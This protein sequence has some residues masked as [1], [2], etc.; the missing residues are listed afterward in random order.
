MFLLL[1][2][3]VLSSSFRDVHAGI[4]EQNPHCR[5]YLAESTIPNAGL[6]I[7]TGI[8]LPANVS[9]A[10]PDIIV[11]LHDLEFHTG[12]N[13]DVDYHFLW[14][15]YSWN[16]SEVGMETDFHNGYA[17]V[18]GTGCVPNCNFALL[19]AIEENKPMYDHGGL[20]RSNDVGISGF[21]GYYNQRM[22]TTRPIPK[23]G[24]IFVDYN[25]DWFSVR[26]YLGNIPYIQHYHNVDIFLAKFKYLTM[27]HD[28]NNY[29]YK[30][31]RRRDGT[32]LHQ[33]TDMTRDLW[34]IV[35]SLSYFGT[36]NANALPI[37]FNDVLVAHNE[38]SAQSRQPYAIRTSEW[39]TTNGK[40]MDNI[41]PGN[42]SIPQAGR[43]AFASRTIPKGQLVAPGPLLHIPNRTSLL[44]YS[45]GTDG[46]RN[47]S[48]GP[49][50][51]QLIL[52]YCFGHA[53]S[54]V[55]LCPYTSP[56]AYINH[57]SGSRTNVQ[58]VWS[59]ESTTPNHNAHWL[60][61]D[62][63]YLKSM[64]SVGL[65][66]DFVAT[67]DI[68]PGE[69]VFLDYGIEWEMAWN[70]YVRDW[71][72]PLGSET[73]YFPASSICENEPLRTIDE[74]VIEPY[75][76]NIIF[77]CHY[78]YHPGM[79]EGEYRWD[80]AWA[81]EL[82]LIPCQ[83]ITREYRTTFVD[84]VGYYYSTIMLTLDQVDVSTMMI[85]N[86]DNTDDD[87]VDIPPLLLSNDVIPPRGTVHVLT[88]VPRWAIK[89][90]DKMYS[91]DEYKVRSFRHEM[92]IPND[93]F[94]EMWKNIL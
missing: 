75:P 26:P 2:Q 73:S 29:Y 15:D 94:P 64:N 23:G 14:N 44:L 93:M 48:A 89:V 84:T 61:E 3:L 56:S 53:Q 81:S 37:T 20:H 66:I 52:N 19:N 18:L 65:S 32:L 1:L 11:P 87:E 55:L 58:I 76:D 91:K 4:V 6:G 80:N 31:S 28:S 74:Q 34:D 9:I 57:G 41:R 46:Q 63:T 10:E 13:I 30:D 47:V 70:D 49:I 77:Y 39:L 90:R 36:R 83:I 69:E 68:L 60:D 17:L 79:E 51:Y 45:V 82:L 33:D 38:G 54:S 21:T 78:D 71:T 72:P 40:C 42:S 86:I 5:L 88:D 92:M 35:K 7:Y 67:R 43:G 50:G 27:K 59:N 85:S 22:I 62:V 12:N 16:P 8:D 24:E 25:E